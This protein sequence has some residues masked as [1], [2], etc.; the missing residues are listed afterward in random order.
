[1]GVNP[2][3]DGVK[4]ATVLAA[5]MDTVPGTLPPAVSFSVNVE[6]LPATGELIVA[7]F[8]GWLKIATTEVATP[9]F[10]LVETLNAALDGL[11]DR[12]VGSAE[13]PPATPTAPGVTVLPG[14]AVMGPLEP[15]HPAIAIT[16]NAAENH[17]FGAV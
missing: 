16:I 10:W 15:P 17:S 12:T 14:A 6:R 3:A 1:M 2:V 13:V 4:V 7:G 8:M 5:F 11:E 9:A